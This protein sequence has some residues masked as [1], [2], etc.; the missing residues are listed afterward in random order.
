MGKGS[1]L[2]PASSQNI[3]NVRVPRFFRTNLLCPILCCGQVSYA[4]FAAVLAFLIDQR[5]KEPFRS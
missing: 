5:S 1:L 2:E 3:T 4:S